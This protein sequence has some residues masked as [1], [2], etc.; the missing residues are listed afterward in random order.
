MS[1]WSRARQLRRARSAA[2]IALQKR[3]GSLS[4]GSSESQATGRGSWL[5]Q[6]AS[7]V[8]L[9]NPAPAERSAKGSAQ[10]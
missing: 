8:V 2:K 10:H 4:R 9:P 3:S 6:A 1:S 5:A 7:R